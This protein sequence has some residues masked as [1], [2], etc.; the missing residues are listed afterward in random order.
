LKEQGK[1][2]RMDE[3]NTSHVGALPALAN[4]GVADG[5]MARVLGILKEYIAK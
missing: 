3:Y 2:I 5:C 1:L 4:G